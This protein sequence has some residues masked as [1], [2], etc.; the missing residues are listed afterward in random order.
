[1]AHFS[2]LEIRQKAGQFKRKAEKRDG[3][4]KREFTLESGTVDTSELYTYD[5]P[6]F[7]CGILEHGSQR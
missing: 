1:M 7:H 5:E 2:Q 3:A 6:L 4:K